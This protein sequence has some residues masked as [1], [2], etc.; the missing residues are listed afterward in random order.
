MA[1]VLMI[2]DN[3]YDQKLASDLLAGSFEFLY[4]QNLQDALTIMRTLT[5]DVVLL[6]LNLPDSR[7]MATLTEL[8]KTFPEVPI[9]VWSG[10]GEAAEAI[11]MGADEFILKGTGGD[12]EVV[13]RALTSAIARHPFKSVRED[14]KALQKLIETDKK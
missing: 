6:D 3:P 9:V 12:I 14:I 13:R 4:T 7:G 5:P 2:E 11:R 10:I 8:A 1:V